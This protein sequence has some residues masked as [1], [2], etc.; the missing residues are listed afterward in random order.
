MAQDVI[1]IRTRNNAFLDSLETPGHEKRAVDAANLFTRTQV[2]EDGFY[3][4]ILDPIYLTNDEL[5]PLPDSDRM[6]KV[7]DMEPGQPAARTIPFATAPDQEFI[8]VPRY[9]VRGSR[10]VG[11]HFVAD[12]DLLRTYRIDIRQ[13]LSD[14]SLKDILAEEDDKLISTANSIMGGARGATVAATGSVQ[15][16]EI[17]GG[18]TRES[19]EDS[20]KILPSTPSHL[21]TAV[22]IINNVTLREFMKWGRDEMG[23]DKSQ[24]VLFDGWT[25]E[26]IGKN[27][28]IVTI[29][30]NLVADDTMFQFGHQDFLG[31]SFIFTDVT[32]YIKK[33]GPMIGYHHYETIGGTLIVTGVARADYT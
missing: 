16:D 22:S 8:R 25:A 26:Q 2:R 18:I 27:K 19:Y 5:D 17:P 3:R 15:W 14:N 29:K 13:V 9:V 33:E 30:R 20:L 1:D 6:S 28:L 12:V 24:D 21:E 11:P 31:K 10:V 4:K 7:V 32:L 23:G